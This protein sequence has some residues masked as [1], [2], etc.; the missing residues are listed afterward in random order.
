MT[1]PTVAS[2]DV[3]NALG[4]LAEPA[5]DGLVTRTLVATGHIDQFTIVPGPAGPLAVAFNDHGIS[6]V[7]PSGDADT[8]AAALEARTGRPAVPGELPTRLARSLQRA[9]RT[10]K[11]GALAIDTRSMSEFQ[12]TVLRKAAEIPPGELRPYGWLAREIGRPEASRAV[13][14]ALARNPVP[15]LLPCH[16]VSRSDGSIGNYAFGSEMKQDLLEAEGLDADRHT[17]EVRRG[18]RYLGTDTTNVYCLTT[19]RH[20]RRI[21]DRHRQEFPSAEAAVAAGKRPCQVCRPA[22]A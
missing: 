8:D 20:A 6:G 15:V 13:G 21:T 7:V 16:R 19:C 12:I 10:G 1:N 5:P 11:I 3:I 17:D 18:V 9:I 4:E 14:T 22:A 2:A